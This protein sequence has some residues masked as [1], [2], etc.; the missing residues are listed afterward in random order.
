MIEATTNAPTDRFLM[1]SQ[2]V[3]AALEEDRAHWQRPFLMGGWSDYNF[4][5]DDK[6][7]FIGPRNPYN[8][9]RSTNPYNRKRSSNPFNN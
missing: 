9:R 6:S 7:N 5:E 3:E 4:K 2:N 1:K 8:R